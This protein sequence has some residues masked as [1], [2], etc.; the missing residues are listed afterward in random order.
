MSLCDTC[1]NPG[2]CCSGFTLNIGTPETYL[3][4]LVLMATV[5]NGTD[6]TREG[7]FGQ[8]FS[9][10]DKTPE[11]WEHVWLGLPFLPLWKDSLGN[12]RYWCIHLSANGR[13]TIYEDRPPLCRE[14]KAGSCRLC[15]EWEPSYTADEEVVDEGT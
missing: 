11:D 3:E 10:P 14:Y 6:P 4:A 2:Q 12:W 9:L 5:G 13:C 1:R 15:A 8:S 7:L